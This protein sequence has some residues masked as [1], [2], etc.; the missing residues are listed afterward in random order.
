MMFPGSDIKI[1]SL[2]KKELRGKKEM[3]ELFTILSNQLRN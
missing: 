2:G 1:K 3:V